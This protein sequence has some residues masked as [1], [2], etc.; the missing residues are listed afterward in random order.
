VAWNSKKQTLVA[1]STTEAE[2]IAAAQ[3]VSELKFLKT[4]LEE[5][6]DKEI[7]IKMKV[8]NLNAIQMVQSGQIARHCKHVEIKFHYI[9]DEWKK[10]WF[11]IEYCNTNDNIADIMTKPL[12]AKKFSDF[13]KKIVGRV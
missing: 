12:P 4:F 13:R 6:M 5:L 8:D 7:K 3:C 11:Q 9:H 2:Y 1:K 10:N